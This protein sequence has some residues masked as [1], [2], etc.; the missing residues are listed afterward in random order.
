MLVW[1]TRLSRK[2]R[3]HWKLNNMAKKFQRI[4]INKM[5]DGVHVMALENVPGKRTTQVR[6][7]NS[8]EPFENPPKVDDFFC[9]DYIEHDVDVA[10]RLGQKAIEIYNRGEC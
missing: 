7:T 8:N 3:I 6:C 5:I 9:P 4:I 1:Y 2:F 10:N